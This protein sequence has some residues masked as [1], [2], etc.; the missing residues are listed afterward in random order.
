MYRCGVK[1][2]EQ[3]SNKKEEVQMSKKAT[4]KGVGRRNFLK[5]AAV[6]AGAAGLAALGAK[7]V[8]AES[9]P[10]LPA[11]WDKEADVVVVGAGATGLPAALEAVERGASVILT[12]QHSDVGGSGMISWGGTGLGGGTRVQKLL[13]IEDS[14]DLIF[15]DLTDSKYELEF[16]KNDR[17]VVRAFADNSADTM[18]WLEEHGVKFLD[19]VIS[20][21]QYSWG[22]SAAK[23]YRAS[24]LE[25][26]Q[27]VE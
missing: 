12:D 26:R 1:K 5:G 8:K 15:K 22:W 27:Q 20:R 3:K 25:A 11:K 14:A 21:C 23:S 17:A 9:K 10:W 24:T 2:K 7:E 6:A 18:K 13:G 16:K 19:D 4:E